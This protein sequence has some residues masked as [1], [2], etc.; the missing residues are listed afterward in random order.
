[1]TV[2]PSG[3]VATRGTRRVVFSGIVTGEIAVHVGAWALLATVTLSVAALTP[4]RPSEA[5]TP[6]W[7]APESAK[8]G[9]SVMV[10]PE[11]V[12][13]D[14][15][16][17][18]V[19]WSVSPSGSVAITVTCVVMPSSMV[20]G[21]SVSM[22]GARLTPPPPE[23]PPEPPPVVPAPVPPPSS[24]PPEPPAPPSTLPPPLQSQLEDATTTT[25]ASAPRALRIMWEFP[26]Q[27]SSRDASA[28]ASKKEVGRAYNR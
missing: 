27:S 19:S 21:A 28:R 6:S 18:R 4:P 20:T 24:P 15:G 22:A 2:C 8:V 5:C 1:M 9:A 16:A 17:V 10:L 14:G 23:P 25:R 12:A 13:H 26:Q 11:M 3:S 7:Y